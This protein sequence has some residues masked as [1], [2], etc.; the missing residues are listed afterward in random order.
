MVLFA[1]DD[2]HRGEK[3][4]RATALADLTILNARVEGTAHANTNNIIRMTIKNQ[5]TGII[6]CRDDAAQNFMYLV[7]RQSDWKNYKYL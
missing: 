2:D 1:V 6:A 7:V 4:A 5:G 3:V